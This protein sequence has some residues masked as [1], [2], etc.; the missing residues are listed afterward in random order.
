MLEPPKLAE[1]TIATAL[2]AHYG[3]SIATI[4]FLPLG[5]DSASAAYRVDA[6]DGAA[7]FLKTRSRIGFSPASVSVPLHLSELGV[8]H[9]LAPLP[10]K[11]KSA[12]VMADDFAL[13]L[14]P[15]VNGRIGG[16]VGLSEQQWIAL[17]KTVKQ[18]H[19]SKLAPDLMRIVPRETFVP[20][21]RSVV[22]DL[23]K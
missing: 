13:I 23:E 5:N 1:P 18:I 17:G 9:I 16:D 19:M 14:C 2:R 10:T 22:T 21:R 20:S 8:P 12:W 7:Y 11:S 3:I 6:A 4:A 15:F